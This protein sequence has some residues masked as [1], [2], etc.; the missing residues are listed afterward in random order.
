MLKLISS[1]VKTTTAVVV[2][3]LAVTTASAQDRSELMAQRQTNKLNAELKLDDTQYKKVLDVNKDFANQISQ[4][5]NTQTDKDKKAAALKKLNQ[6]REEK[7]K[8]ILTE[9]QFKTYLSNKEN[10]LKRAA[11]GVNISDDPNTDI[12]QSKQ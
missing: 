6:Q 1:I 4:I 5:K 9:E 7:L 3:L 12:K 10:N 8:G 2:M 11:H